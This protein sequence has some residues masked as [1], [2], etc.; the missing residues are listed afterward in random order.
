MSVRENFG[1]TDATP[2][3]SGTIVYRLVSKLSN[4]LLLHKAIY[5]WV[6]L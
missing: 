2:A 4:D 3:T 6:K 1:V 5:V